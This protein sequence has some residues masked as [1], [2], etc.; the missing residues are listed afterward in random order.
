MSSPEINCYYGMPCV[1]VKNNNDEDN[2]LKLVYW[3]FNVTFFGQMYLV[4]SKIW[5]LVFSVCIFVGDREGFM[6]KKYCSSLGKYRSQNKNLWKFKTTWW[7]CDVIL[8]ND[9]PALSVV[10]NC[11]LIIETQ[12]LGTKLILRSIYLISK[13]WQWS[14]NSWTTSNI[15]LHSLCAG[16]AAHRWD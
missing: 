6:G 13:K 3:A 7:H 5:I 11:N 2:N 4:Q 8:K 15:S 14:H 9:H 10:L 16:S 12:N 1:C